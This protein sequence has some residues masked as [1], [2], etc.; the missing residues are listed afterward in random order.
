MNGLNLDSTGP[1]EPSFFHKKV[2][3]SSIQYDPFDMSTDDVG[4]K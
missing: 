2:D 3:I 1:S 4:D